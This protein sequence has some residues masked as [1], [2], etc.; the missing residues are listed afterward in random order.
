MTADDGDDRRLAQRVVRRRDEAAFR[1]L[2]ARHTPGLYATALRLTGSAAD[3]ADVVHDAWI[4]AVEHLGRFQ[5]RSSLRT[6]LAGI[7]VNVVRERWRRH[8]REEPYDDDAAEPGPSHD[9]HAAIDLDAAV[10]RLAPRYRE[11]FV[12]HDIEGFTH[13]EIGHMLGIDAG[14]SKSQLAR[15]RRHL[16]RMLGDEAREQV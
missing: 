11:V 2:Y 3:A 7:V 15:A 10:A 5:G 8:S 12:L 16:R 6:W 14:T 9:I 13:D 4:R 1:Q